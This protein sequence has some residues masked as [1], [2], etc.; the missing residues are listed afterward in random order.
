[1]A[2]RATWSREITPTTLTVATKLTPR[3]RQAAEETGEGERKRSERLGME[4]LGDIRSL[5]LLWPV[6]P[7]MC[8]DKAALVL[9]RTLDGYV[10]GCCPIS[11]VGGRS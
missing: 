1:V 4:A 2:V 10:T 11:C 8:A 7:H 5:L 3:P 6:W 9:S